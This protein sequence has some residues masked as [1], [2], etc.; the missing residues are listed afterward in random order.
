MIYK[1][2]Y[3]L[4]PKAIVT[5]QHKHTANKSST[6]LNVIEEES[7]VN[8]IKSFYDNVK[9]YLKP[10]NLQHGKLIGEKEF[11]NIKPLKVSKK[12]YKR[13]LI[14]TGYDTLDDINGN[15]NE[16]NLLKSVMSSLD[17]IIQDRLS[18]KHNKSNEYDIMSNGEN[19]VRKYKRLN[20]TCIPK[21]NINNISLHKIENN[22]NNERQVSKSKLI[23]KK[24]LFSN[25][26]INDIRKNSIGKNNS[27]RHNSLINS[28]SQSSMIRSVEDSLS[29]VTNKVINKQQS[30]NPVKPNTYKINLRKLNPKNN[31]IEV[32]MDHTP[33]TK[34]NMSISLQEDYAKVKSSNRIY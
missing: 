7:Y 32:I 31:Y 15:E 5:S 22:I 25:K 13:L 8:T 29:H 28:I 3:Y 30:S 17:N 26:I 12:F 6:T 1:K 14:N 34:N 11:F 33:K 18:T 23:E 4:K 27:K 10:K 9:V 20:S 21:R 19:K 2:K 16:G 24:K